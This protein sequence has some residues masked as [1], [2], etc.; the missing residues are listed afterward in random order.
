MKQE[1]KINKLYDSKIFWVIVSLLCSLLLWGYVSG[2]DSNETTMTLTGIQVEFKGEDSLAERNMS[3]YDL[4][5]SS[6]NVRVKGNRSVLSKLKSSDIKAVL[7]VSNIQQ[8]NDMSWTY[9]LEFP[10]YVDKNNIQI[11]SQTPQRINFTVEKNTKKTVDVKGEF[12]GHFAE[13]CAGDALPVFEPATITLEGRES[14]LKHIECAWVDFG[15]PDLYIDSTYS[16]DKSFTLVDKDGKACSTTD[17]TMSA[18]YVKATQPIIKTKEIPLKI[19]LI[20]GGGITEDECIVTVEPAEIKI[21]GDSLLLD[22]INEI[23]LGDLDLSAVDGDYERKYEIPLDEDIQ[24]VTGTT[25]A[26]VKI[27]VSETYT[28]TF[29]T[30]NI[31]CKNV[32]KGYKATIDTQEVEVSLRAKDQATLNSIES[33]DISI[34]AD[35]T[36]Y[37]TTTGQVMVNGK[38]S[39]KG[40]S[41]VGAVGDVKVTLTI[42]KE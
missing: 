2:Q 18:N 9:D 8:P 4:D 11:M 15:D 10:D 42:S 7:D 5:V 25:E 24:N 26:T 31:S 12:D 20:P 29:T 21:A 22:D 16:I 30:D 13:G 40:H 38:V 32:S 1:K 3:V 14:A 37:G 34:V 33:E 17:I 28:K 36:D 6:V 27:T 41:D 35:L 23:V 19:K 39:V